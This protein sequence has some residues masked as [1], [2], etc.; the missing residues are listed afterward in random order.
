MGGTVPKVRDGIFPGVEDCLWG[1]EG[2]EGR[3]VRECGEQGMECEAFMGKEWM[4]DT[5]LLK[6]PAEIVIFDEEERNEWEGCVFSGNQ[7]NDT[8]KE[9]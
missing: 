1:D 2:K 3:G 8:R 7:E 5:V 4:A 6:V 9:G